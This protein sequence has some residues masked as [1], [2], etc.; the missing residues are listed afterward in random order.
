MVIRVQQQNDEVVHSSCLDEVVLAIKLETIQLELEAGKSSWM[1]L[2]NRAGM[3]R[4]L[5]ISSMLGLFTQW[6][7][8]TLISY[9]LGDLLKMIGFSDSTFVQ[10]INVS[11]SCSNFFFAV[12]VSLLVMRVRRRIM[13]MICT[14]SLLTVYIAWTISMQQ[15]QTA[16]AAGKPNLAANVATIFFIYAYS[17]CYNIGYNALTYSKYGLKRSSRTLQHNFACIESAFTN[18]STAYLVELWPYAERSHGIAAF[19]FW[20]RSAGFFTTFVNPIG[21][22]NVGWKY[23]ISYCCWL[24]F[25]IVF[26]YFMFPETYG[27]TLEE[28]AFSKIPYLLGDFVIY[29]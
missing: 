27:R 10:K 14:I 19:Q 3:R 21:I 18:E 13:Y 6:S 16:Q 12:L 22:A 15:A 4:R 28:L 7:G 17:P 29:C 5:F 9:Y 8:N 2:F 24:A 11:I 23:L 25:E 1:D 20:G 26:V